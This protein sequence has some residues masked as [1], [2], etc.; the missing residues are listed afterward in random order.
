MNHLEDFTQSY[1]Q[2]PWRKQLQVVGLF[3]LALVLVALVAGIYLSVSA[4][5][6]A[7]GRD[8]QSMQ[9]Q[10]E[11]LDREIEDLQ[12][13][14]AASRSSLEME[15]RAM[16]LG[17]QPVQSDQVLYLNIPGYVERQPAILAPAEQRVLASAPVLPAQYTESLFTW[18][19]RQI[20]DQWTAVSSQRPGAKP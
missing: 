6:A 3:L 9:G 5:T 1:S 10:I 16:Q 17:F 15:A 13:L 19:K 2:A 12:S 14:L 20:S 4:R 11:T 7:V 18:A 8:I